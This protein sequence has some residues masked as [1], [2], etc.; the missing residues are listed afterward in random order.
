MK[1]TG[2]FAESFIRRQQELLAIKLRIEKYAHVNLLLFWFFYL[3]QD[4]RTIFIWGCLLTAL[5][6]PCMSDMYLHFP[7]GSNNRLNGDGENVQNANRLFNSQVTCH[8]IHSFYY[9]WCSDSTL[10]Q[11]HHTLLKSLG[12]VSN[13]PSKSWVSQLFRQISLVLQSRSFCGLVL[14]SVSFY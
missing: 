3:T 13:A 5:I 2:N 12:G 11:A 9:W 6:D 7:P 8:Y 14:L 10:L 1:S 4:M